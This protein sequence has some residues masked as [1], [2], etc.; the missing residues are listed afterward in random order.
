MPPTSVPTEAVLNAPATAV[1]GLIAVIL[2]VAL[3]LVLRALVG[4]EIA[5]V[6]AEIDILRKRSHQHA[7]KITALLLRARI[8]E[9][10][11]EDE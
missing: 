7:S 5:R 8:P 9:S 10:P 11:E 6:W 1:L 3:V 2:V 4:K